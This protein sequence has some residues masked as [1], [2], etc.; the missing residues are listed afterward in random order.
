M[1]TTPPPRP[2]RPLDPHH[3]HRADRHLD[4]TRRHPLAH[5]PHHQPHPPH[6]PPNQNNNHPNTNRQHS[7]IEGSVLRHSASWTATSATAQSG[8]APTG[9][10]PV[11]TR[12][13][14]QRSGTAASGAAPAVATNSGNARRDCP[15]S[16]HA[17]SRKP[18]IDGSNRSRPRSAQEPSP[19]TPHQPGTR[20]PGPC[21][22]A[23][24][25]RERRHDRRRHPAQFDPHADS[26]DLEAGW[27]IP[28][29]QSLLATTTGIEAPSR[30]NHTSRNPKRLPAARLMWVVGA[31]STGTS[32][33]RVLFSK[34]PPIRPRFA[35]ENGVGVRSRRRRLWLARCSVLNRL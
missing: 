30:S 5:R 20:R 35:A 25:L 4:P 13:Q 15:T 22:P 12:H 16:G 29:T 23:D 21:H 28:T 3:D 14:Q 18:G 33:T 27:R 7:G 1:R 34:P 8:T 9:T 11:E 26:P 2:R 31:T 19:R 6:Q 17:L 24:E 32:T 10:T